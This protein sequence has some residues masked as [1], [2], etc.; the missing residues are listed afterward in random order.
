A[1]PNIISR[2]EWGA[3]PSKSIEYLSS[4]PVAYAFIHHSAGKECFNQT[5]CAAVVRGYQDFHMDTREWDDIGYSYVIGGDG[6]VFEGRGWDRVGAHTL[7]YNRVGLGFCL[8]GNF[9]THLPTVIQ[10]DTAK[11]LIAC[12]VSLGK[13]S[14]NYTLRGH[15]DM[16]PT[17]S[18]PGDLFYSLIQTWDHY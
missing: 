2:A 16:V 14:S 13:I 7:S 8:A 3:R 15:R 17:T 4:Q 5:D 6:T 1:C 18:C 11:K 10:M 9:M 12:G